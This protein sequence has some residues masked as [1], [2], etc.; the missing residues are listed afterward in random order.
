MGTGIDELDKL[1]DGGKAAASDVKMKWK[2]KLA[3]VAVAGIGALLLKFSSDPTMTK[4][5]IGVI[6]VGVV[7]IL[8]TGGVKWVLKEA[9]SA[10]KNQPRTKI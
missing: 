2:M 5:A 9:Y 8:G 7:M 3:G 10:G 1:V 6:V 4:I